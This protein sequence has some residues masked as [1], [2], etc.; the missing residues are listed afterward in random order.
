MNYFAIEKHPD[1]AQ[2][3]IK[4][5]ANDIREDFIRSIVELADKGEPKICTDVIPLDWAVMAHNS[6]R[7]KNRY[8]VLIVPAAVNLGEQG[9]AH[10]YFYFLK[11]SEMPNSN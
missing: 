2:Q 9:S 1:D 11:K 3:Y 4:V 5:P 7:L 10:G 6:T 8:F